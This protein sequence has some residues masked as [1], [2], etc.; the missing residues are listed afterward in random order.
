[1]HST[2]PEFIS[3]CISNITVHMNIQKIRV[4]LRKRLF[5]ISPSTPPPI[6]PTPPIIAI[7][8]HFQPPRL[9]PPPRLFGTQEYLN[10][11]L[12]Q[13]ASRISHA[14]VF[15]A[16]VSA[17]SSFTSVSSKRKELFRS[18]DIDIPS[19]GETRWYYRSRT[20]GVI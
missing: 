9:F 2:E 20:I 7:S 14:K 16:N 4:Y 3:N 12:C 11:L 5:S 18:H 10:L 17:V 1:M 19:P 13:K 6:I 8:N 15:F